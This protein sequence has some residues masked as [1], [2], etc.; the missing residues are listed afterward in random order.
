M[1]SFGKKLFGIKT[2]KSPPPPAP[3]PTIETDT[4]MMDEYSR[5]KKRKG[6]AQ[7]VLAGDLIP[8]DIGKRT[9]LG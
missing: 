1:G 8:E 7:T 4:D 3:A 6:R 2:P 5:L 9:L